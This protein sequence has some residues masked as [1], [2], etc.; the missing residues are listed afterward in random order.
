MALA[1][2]GVSLSSGFLGPILILFFVV[3]VARVSLC[4]HIDCDCASL[5][6]L[7]LLVLVSVLGLSCRSLAARIFCSEHPSHGLYVL[8]HVLSRAVGCRYKPGAMEADLRDAPWRPAY[9]TLASPSHNSSVSAYNRMKSTFYDGYVPKSPKAGTPKGRHTMRTARAS[10]S[11]AVA[12]PA[13]LQHPNEEQRETGSKCR[14]ALAGLRPL[15]IRKT[16]QTSSTICCPKRARN[17]RERNRPIP[18]TAPKNYATHQSSTR[19]HP[20]MR[21]GTTSLTTSRGAC[22]SA[23]C[24]R[25]G[26]GGYHWRRR[27]G[28]CP[29]RRGLTRRAR[30]DVGVDK[31][32]AEGHGE[33][34]RACRRARTRHWEPERPSRARGVGRSADKRHSAQQPERKQK[35]SG[36]PTTT[37]NNISHAKTNDVTKSVRTSAAPSQ[38]LTCTRRCECPATQQPIPQPPSA[39]TSTYRMRAGRQRAPP[40]PAPPPPPPLPTWSHHACAAACA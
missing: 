23:R 25:W 31:D 6:S 1:L 2:P 24:R 9:L 33:T 35:T 4:M 20:I 26:T 29:R 38:P 17:T 12:E 8:L 14:S 10:L 3:L 13:A 37:I 32:R 18:G 34:K 40:R 21:G 19:V 36:P 39:Q 11:T 27:R 16:S 15:M 28:L 7:P 30:H 5:V 22:G